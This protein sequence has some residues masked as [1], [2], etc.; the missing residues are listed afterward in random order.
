MNIITIIMTCSC[1]CCFVGDSVT[2]SVIRSSEIYIYNRS[3]HCSL[4]SQ[5]DVGSLDIGST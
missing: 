1:K 4:V 5:V 3:V 2:V